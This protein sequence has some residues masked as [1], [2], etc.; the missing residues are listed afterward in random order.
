MFQITVVT[1]NLVLTEAEKS[2]I[3]EVLIS[4]NYHIVLI[5]K[6][7]LVVQKEISLLIGAPYSFKFLDIEKINEVKIIFLKKEM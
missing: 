4:I 3:I 7:I 1:K 6:Q 2:A 5:T